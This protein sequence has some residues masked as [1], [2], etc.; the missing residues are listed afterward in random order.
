MET[1]LLPTRQ[2]GPRQCNF[3]SL[4]DVNTAPFRFCLAHHFSLGVLHSQ[5][6]RPSCG[7]QREVLEDGGGKC[8]CLIPPTSD[9]YLEKSIQPPDQTSERPWSNRRRP[10]LLQPHLT[11]SRW[12][13]RQLCLGLK[14]KE[15]V[16][17]G[18]PRSLSSGRWTGCLTRCSQ[19][20]G[21]GV[22]VPSPRG[23]WNEHAV[24]VPLGNV[25]W[26]KGTWPTGFL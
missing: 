25:P 15:V 2:P 16:R 11:Q 13:Q 24:H 3:G 12:H 7:S 6:A 14:G 18:V 23:P 9:Y 26:G 22:T 19:G 20:P 1:L 10:N 4:S 5:K 17:S 21:A 8:W